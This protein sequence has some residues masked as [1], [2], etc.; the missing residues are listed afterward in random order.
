LGIAKVLNKLSNGLNKLL[1]SLN[2]L[3]NRKIHTKKVSILFYLFTCNR[4]IYHFVS[5]L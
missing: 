4:S 3:S 1:N 5:S 2:K